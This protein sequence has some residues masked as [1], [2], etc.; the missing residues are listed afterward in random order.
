MNDTGS[1]DA[2][3]ARFTKFEEMSPNSRSFFLRT[4]GKME[5]GAL[6]AAIFTLISTAIG[7]GCLTLP[8]VFYR[9]GII[10]GFILLVSACCCSFMGIMN[11]T[12]AAE[13]F[14]VFEYSDLILNVLGKKW[15]LLFDNV[16]IL[17]VIGTLIG[18]QVMV[19][20]F[21]PSIFDSL[22]INFEPNIERVI[23]MVG[24]NVLIMAPLGVMRTLTSLRFMSIVSALTL[25]YIALLIICEFPFFN[26]HNSYDNVHIFDVNLSIISSFNICLYAFTCHTN[27]AQVYKELN[28]KNLRRMG[29][30]AR[31]AML[32]VL[33]PFSILALFGYLSTLSHTPNLIIMRRAPAAI[34]NDWLMVI[35]R[36][37]MSITLVIAVPINIPPCRKCIIKTWLRNNDEHPPNTLHY[38]VTLALLGVTLLVAI[39]FQGILIVFSIL[40]GFCCGLI[41]LVIPS[42]LK[43]KTEKYEDKSWKAIGLRVGS[44]SLFL[45]GTTGAILSVIGID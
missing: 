43:V 37:L 19:G 15:K 2:G 8:L 9:Q 11:I 18:Y 12:T 6:R 45:L 3:Q 33:I 7:A 16:L 42:F 28:N 5:A 32:T 35:A 22:N 29:K 31:R 13:N 17:Y 44:V 40:G 41:V 4:V 34:S 21:V 25:L 38:G 20:N 10:L 14:K 1:Y 39:F 23:I 24:A 26:R 36:I 30:V 27:V